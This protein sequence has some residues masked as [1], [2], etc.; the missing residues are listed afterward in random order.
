MSDTIDLPQAEAFAEGIG[1][2]WRGRVVSTH[3]VGRTTDGMRYGHITGF[4]RSGLGELQV[5][6]I[7]KGA[8]TP[9]TINSTMLILH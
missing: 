9:A 4:V 5:S 1:A 3:A 6:V 2:Y 8:S 7:W